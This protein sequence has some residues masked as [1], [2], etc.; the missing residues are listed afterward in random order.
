MA[1]MESVASI[2]LLQGGYAVIGSV[3]AGA[4]AN[5]RSG[6]EMVKR[7]LSLVPSLWSLVPLGDGMRWR[8]AAGGW[9]HVAKSVLR[10]Y[11][12][13]EMDH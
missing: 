4:I 11:T 9:R 6:A 1:L 5:L 7:R 8:L 2:S 3:P 10:R 13:H 12:L